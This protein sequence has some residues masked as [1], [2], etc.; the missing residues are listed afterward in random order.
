[1]MK[2]KNKVFSLKVQITLFLLI[3]LL[4]LIGQVGFAKLNQAQL[5]S[6]FSNY[7]KTITEEKLVRELERD[8]LD[9]QRQVL[10]FKN[11]GSNSAVKRFDILFSQIKSKLD[12]IELGIS[13]GQDS[14]EARIQIDSMQLHI[15]DYFTN[16]TNVVAERKQRDKYFKEGLI[17]NIEALFTNDE[18]I[19]L[20][21]QNDSLNIY[22][23]SAENLAYRYLLNPSSVLKKQ[24]SN[25]LVIAKEIIKNIEGYTQDKVLVNA[26]IDKVNKTFLQ[27]THATQGYI[28][29]VNVIMAGSAN[30]F[31]YLSQEM[32]QKSALFANETNQQIQINISKSQ[33]QMN[34]SSLVGILITTLLAFIAV[35]RIF[36]PLHGITRVFER[37]AKGEDAVNIPFVNRN[38]EIG[39]LASSASVFSKK[40]QQTKELL[41]QSQQLNNEQKTLNLE[42]AEA[43]NQA[44]IANASKSKFLANMSHEIRTPMN[45]IIGLVDMSLQSS[46]TPKVRNHLEKVAYSSQILLNVIKDILDFSKIEAGKLDIENSPFSLTLLFGSLSAFL[47]S[48]A[49][50]KEINVEVFIDPRLPLNAIGDSLRI[51]QVIL[52]LTNNAIKFTHSGTISI[53]FLHKKSAEPDTFI[54]EVQIKDSGVGIEEDRLELIFSPFT[55]G[56]NSISRQYGGTGLGLSIVKQLTSLMNGEVSATSKI[57]CGSTFTCSFKL[58]R[59][60]VDAIS[61]TIMGIKKMLV[62]VSDSSPLLYA[63]YVNIIAPAAVYKSYNDLG[64]FITQKETVFIFDI[65]DFEHAQSLHSVFQH[66]K[67]HKVNFGCVTKMQPMPL[68]QKIT[69]E[70]Q[71]PVI[72]QPFLF[73]NINHFISRLNN[74]AD[75]NNESSLL[76]KAKTKTQVAQLEG[77]ILLVE[78]NEINQIL[79]G[80]MLKNLGLTYDIANDGSEA[81]EAVRINRAYDAVL[82]DVQMPVL[83][84][85][86]ATKMIRK[87][88]ETTLPIIG[89]SAHALKE[90]RDIALNSG[91]NDYLTK[92]IQHETLVKA[93]QQILEPTN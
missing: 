47:V 9:L 55:Q 21:Q 69:A 43:I 78:D 3:F 83:D 25:K 4:I 65:N 70:Y 34:I 19:N 13:E 51:S 76:Y 11:N 74:N 38:D 10:I 5:I 27:L 84:G 32:A 57:G 67:E 41:E 20:T 36:I 89:I 56:D 92:P 93:L 42:L 16:F 12:K 39:R 66:F 15:E 26:Q 86:E 45:G 1:M 50:E 52:N 7:Q 68:G 91:M 31:L 88:G 72:S 81:V 53:S 80:E 85:I 24:F 37:L 40:N 8:V 46:L 64:D 82:M 29:L 22:F 62:Y 71:C 60:G 77:H 6:E 59:E 63:E 14:E 75:V 30:E 48:P 49:S 90:D 73:D 28:Y 58:I 35:T 61:T 54:L 17:L 23:Y 79:M 87:S 33:F 44:E 2:N 18:F